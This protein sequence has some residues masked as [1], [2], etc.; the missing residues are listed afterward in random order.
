M[1]FSLPN[2]LTL[3]PLSELESPQK[4]GSESTFAA[5]VVEPPVPSLFFKRQYRQLACVEVALPPLP[6]L[7]A[8]SGPHVAW[9]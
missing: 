9:Q 8:L 6:A 5:P 4:G 1:P 3:Q 7:D 2:C